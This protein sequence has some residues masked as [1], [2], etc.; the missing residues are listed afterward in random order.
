MEN[1]KQIAELEE[2][3]MKNKKYTAEEIREAVD[4]ATGDDGF[5]SK[6]VISIL[7]TNVSKKNRRILERK[8]NKK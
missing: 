3:C 6:E 7:K 5:R 1:L 4:I 8:D 2:K